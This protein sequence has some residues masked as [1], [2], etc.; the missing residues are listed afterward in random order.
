MTKKPNTMDFEPTEQPEEGDSLDWSELE[1][2]SPDESNENEPTDLDALAEIYPSALDDIV[3][4]DN[5]DTLKLSIKQNQFS[6]SFEAML[7]HQTEIINTIRTITPTTF[8]ECASLVNLFN[9]VNEFLC[10]LFEQLAQAKTG[11]FVKGG[12]K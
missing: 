5:D 2:F 11:R 3:D 1:D 12:G 8:E 9:G 6:Q 10:L 7:L 4:L